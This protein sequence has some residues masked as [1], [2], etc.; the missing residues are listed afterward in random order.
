MRTESP[1]TRPVMRYYGGKFRVAADIVRLMPRHEVYVEPFGG[2]A[3]VL[4][5][6]ARVPCEVYND[7]DG[8]VVNVFRQLR[9]APDALLRGLFL[10][11]YSREEY[12]AAYEPTTDALEAARRFVYRSTA[13]IGSDSS[14][15]LNGFRNSLDEGK[16]AWAPSWEGI[17]ESLIS[18]V[19]RMR[20]VIIENL[21]VMK[22]IERFDAS[23]ALFYC[24]PPY[25]AG[26]RKDKAKGYA[27]EM[28]REEQHEELLDRLLRC[29][30]MVMVS[31]YDHALYR[32]RLKE[33]DRHAFA[34]RNQ[35]N[36]AVHEVVWCN[37]K[38]EGRLL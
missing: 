30:G 5:A 18:V 16:Y 20:G 22:V 21:D 27:F 32:D 4:L 26:T 33:W 15:R 1:C 29:E 28:M 24:D 2:A 34:A 9:D 38:Q 13:G 23:N 36:D 12:R 17:P 25:I 8:A 35:R 11:P 19:E 37:F 6:K 10:T 3:S 31:G 7:L 14:R